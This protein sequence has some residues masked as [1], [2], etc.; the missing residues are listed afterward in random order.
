MKIII[1]YFISENTRGIR[2]SVA[3]RRGVPV[4]VRGAEVR[5]GSAAGGDSHISNVNLSGVAVVY[6]A[7][8]CEF[9]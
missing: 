4:G 6:L 9:Y 2:R 7:F 1:G 5:R 3:V 8:G